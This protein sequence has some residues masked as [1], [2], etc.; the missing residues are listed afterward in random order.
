MSDSAPPAATDPTG[1][2]KNRFVMPGLVLAFLAG[3]ML[4]IIIAISI[5]VS[6]RSF[7]VVPDYYQKAVDWDEHKE[8]LAASDALGW[9]A[10]VLPSRKVSIL[11]KRELAVTLTDSE[12]RPV[13]G[14]DVFVTL[15]PHAQANQ[16]SELVLSATDEPGR[17]SATAE[18]AREGVW[19]VSVH[20]TRGAV[21]YLYEDKLFVRGD[22]EGGR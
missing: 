6:D 16:I 4:F 10:Q 7:A 12:G 22:S 18:M 13:E 20:A 15:Y 2:T 3:H 8:L 5:A 17:Y 11:G 9:S 14:A 21:A 19:S 1:P